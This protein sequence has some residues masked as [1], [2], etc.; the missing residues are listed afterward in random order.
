[1][2]SSCVDFHKNGAFIG[3]VRALKV[4]DGLPRRVGFEQKLR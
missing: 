3:M 1:L 2:K 4:E